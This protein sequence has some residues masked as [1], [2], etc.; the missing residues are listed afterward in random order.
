MFR[1][2]CKCHLDFGEKEDEAAGIKRI[3]SKKSYHRQ[4]LFNSKNDMPK[5][6]GKEQQNTPGSC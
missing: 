3:N 6:N 1:F 2:I 5:L 4:R